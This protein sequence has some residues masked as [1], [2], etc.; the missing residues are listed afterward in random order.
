MRIIPIRLLVAAMVALILLCPLLADDW[1]C[2]KGS[3][4]RMGS[5][6]VSAPNSCYLL[7]EVEAGPELYA[8]SVIS[9]KKVFK[10]ALETL[11][12]RRSWFWSSHEVRPHAYQV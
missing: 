7:W 4:E 12:C 1:I 8:S 2:F 11:Y 5:S 3:P 10:V 6:H 9:N